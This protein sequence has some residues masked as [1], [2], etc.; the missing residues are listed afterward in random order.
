M[1]EAPDLKY[2]PDV[3]SFGQIIIVN[4]ETALFKRKNQTSM[5]VS[6]QSS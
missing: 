5:K 1:A 6:K 3:M 4:P 2:W